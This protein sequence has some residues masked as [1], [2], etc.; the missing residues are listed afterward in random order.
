MRLLKLQKKFVAI[1]DVCNDENSNQKHLIDECLKT[2][3]MPCSVLLE[4]DYSHQILPYIRKLTCFI[5]I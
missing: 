2:R 3:F 5:L 1:F 4:Y